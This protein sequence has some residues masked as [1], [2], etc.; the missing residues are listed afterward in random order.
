MIKARVLHTSG[1]GESQIDERI[2][3]LEILSNPTVGLA[4]HS[5]QV[6]VRI[7]A[8]AASELE[9]DTLIRGVEAEI[10][11]RLGA[12]IYGADGDT[13]EQVAL[14]TLAVNGWKLVVVESGLRGELV[15]RLSNTSGAFARGEVIPQSL[16]GE[17][18]S[19][20]L[21]NYRIEHGTEVG[22]GV[23][24]TSSDR[25][26]DV[27]LILI[28]PTSEEQFIRPYGGPPEYA[29]RW[30]F[31]HSLDVLR[32]HGIDSTQSRRDAKNY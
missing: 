29:P 23:S 17:D 27:I 26:H 11:Q 2:G 25:R 32:L 30:A 5:G 22:L 9:A 19:Q 3:D 20:R 16:S 8:K 28:T 7:T 4:A 24:L 31:H 12:W 21:H 10:R 14:D 18:L 13:L 15:R 6:D 1:V